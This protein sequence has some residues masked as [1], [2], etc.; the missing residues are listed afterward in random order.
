M[1]FLN[2]EEI[3]SQINLESNM[4]AADFGCG[5]GGFT[6]PLAKKLNNGFVYALDIQEPPLEALKSKAGA[7]RITNLKFII[8]DIE[9][10]ETI[11]IPEASLD[12]ISIVNVLFQIQD[13]YS[14]ISHAKKLL[15]SNGFLL[16]VDW[17]PGAGQ[18]PESGRVSLEQ[19]KALG[20]SNG[21][22]AEKE[23]EAG[24]YHYG[25]ILKKP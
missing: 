21:F 15:K 6:I 19:I 18:G 4:I 5:S 10:P 12:F 3:L 8:C 7:E 14:V 13:K 25:V 17:E 20:E 16:V 24:M 23:F 1:L 2:P 22:Q 9:H 11:K